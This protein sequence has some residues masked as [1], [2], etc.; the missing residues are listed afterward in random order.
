MEYAISQIEI[1]NFKTFESF[2]LEVSSDFNIII[3]ENGIGKTTIFEALVLWDQVYKKFIAS[4]NKDFYKANTNYYLNFNEIYML[5]NTT[6]NDVFYNPS[7]KELSISIVMQNKVTPE[8]TFNLKVIIEKPK[9]INDAYFRI[10]NAKTDEQ[11]HEFEKFAKFLSD[12]KI[13]LDQS[14]FI[15]Q[16]KPISTIHQKEPFYNNAQILKK[17]YIGKSLEVLRNKLLKTR[18]TSTKKVVDEFR[19]IES[20]LESVFGHKYEVRFKNKNL[21]DDEYLRITIK[22]AAK[23]ELELS[24]YGSGFLQVIEIFSTLKYLDESKMGLNILLIDEPDSHIHS[25]I[26]S[27][28]IDTLRQIN[29][30]QVFV[31]SHNDRFIKKAKDKELYFLNNSSKQGKTLKYLEINQFEDAKKELGGVLYALELMSSNKPVIFVEGETDEKYLQTTIATSNVNWEVDIFWIGRYNGKSAEYTGDSALNSTKNFILANQSLINKPVILLYDSDTHKN[32]ENH[33][34]ANLFIRVMPTN[35]EN[36]LYKIGVENLLCLQD[37]FSK[38]IYYKEVKK[39]K[40]DNYGAVTSTLS[41][42]LDKTKLCT[43]IC[44]HFENKNLYLTKMADMLNNLKSSL[45]L[46]P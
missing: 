42:S 41:K 4:N 19:F 33:T 20:Q 2:K 35:D 3:G 28:L 17:I 46:E 23:K 22:E 40:I 5:R 29:E 1:Y 21:N 14:F 32:D 10:F 15:Y 8:Q 12:K 7:N 31:I 16:T 30:A 34:D 24:L 13:P 38:D 27:S 36:E 11:Y 39:E 45:P 37:N 43:D 44:D 18:D 26:Q 6:S 9:S 25:N